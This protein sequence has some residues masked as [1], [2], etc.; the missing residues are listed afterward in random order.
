MCLTAYLN[1]VRTTTEE[2]TYYKILAYDKREKTHTSPYMW[3]PIEYG[4]EYEDLKKFHI[5]EAQGYY[6]GKQ[7][8]VHGGGFHLFENYQDAKRERDLLNN[9]HGG[10]YLYVVAKAIV[11]AGTDYMEGYFNTYRSVAVKKVKYEKL[12]K[13]K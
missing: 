4:K 9:R 1:V 6:S 2:Q 3:F 5:D 8:Y 11:P 13:K 10:R 12:N 7:Y